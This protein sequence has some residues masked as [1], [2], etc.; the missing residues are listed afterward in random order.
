MKTY[1]INCEGGGGGVTT[2]IESFTWEYVIHV[3][4]KFFQ[5]FFYKSH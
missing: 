2:G 1:E 3:L 5:I 4:L